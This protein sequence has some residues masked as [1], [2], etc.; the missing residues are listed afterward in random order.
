MSR[1]LTWTLSVDDLEDLFRHT[2]D[3]DFEVAIID[4][5]FDEIT[6]TLIVELIGEDLEDTDEHHGVYTGVLIGAY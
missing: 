5:G 3:R 1:K 4:C 6:E 2:F